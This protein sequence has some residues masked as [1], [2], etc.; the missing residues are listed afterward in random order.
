M[1]TLTWRMRL[2]LY[3]SPPTVCLWVWQCGRWGISFSHVN[4]VQASCPGCRPFWI[5]DGMRE[6]WNSN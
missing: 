6:R 3:S 1:S 2:D 4:G 5:V